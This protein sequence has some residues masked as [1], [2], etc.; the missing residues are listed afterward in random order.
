MTESLTY[1]PMGELAPVGMGNFLS[2]EKREQV[3]RLQERP[4]RILAT[5][6][7]RQGAIATR[8]ELQE[9]IWGKRHVRRLR[10]VAE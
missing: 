1:T 6:V 8:E 7:D 5:P 4:L 10:A 9:R 2:Q 3:I